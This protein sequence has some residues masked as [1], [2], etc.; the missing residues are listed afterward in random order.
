VKFEVKVWISAFY[1]QNESRT[2]IL[3]SMWMSC[4]SPSI[5]SQV[6]V[7]LFKVNGFGLTQHPRSRDFLRDA[8]LLLLKNRASD[9]V[10]HLTI[11][12]KR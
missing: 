1:S 3:S 12:L 8:Q 9:E 2:E 5:D 4:D 6:N 11:P 7:H 10:E